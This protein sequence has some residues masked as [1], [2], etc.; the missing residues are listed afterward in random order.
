V[1]QFPAVDKS[2]RGEITFDETDLYSEAGGRCPNRFPI[3][4]AARHTGRCPAPASLRGCESL[5]PPVAHGELPPGD[6]KDHGTRVCDD[7]L[8]LTFAIIDHE[9]SVNR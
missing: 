2:L 4:T 8:K 5:L 1:N 3:G 7:D 6:A 9:E